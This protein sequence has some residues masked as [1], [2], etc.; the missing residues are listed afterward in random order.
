MAEVSGQAGDKVRIRLAKK[1]VDGILLESHDAGVVLLKLDSGYNIGIPKGNVLDSKIVK[2]FAEKPRKREIK[3]NRD[4]PSIGLVVTGGTIASKLDSR[5]G[6]VKPL[7]DVEEFAKFYPRLFEKVNVKKIETPFMM[8]SE[9]MS[10]RE[11]IKI[12]ESVKKMLDDP[13]IEG[14]IVTHGTDTLHYTAAAL[15]FFLRDLSKPVVLTYSQRSIDRASSDAE[16]NLECA[17]RMVLAEAAEVMLVGHASINDDFCYA[18]RGV[19]VCKLHTSRRDAFKS[20]NERPIA[21]VWPDKVEFLSEYRL[22]NDK[23]KT[24]LDTSFS[25]KVG[26]VKYYP[27]QNSDILDYY[28]KRYK[29]IVIEATGLGHVSGVEA[30]DNWIP[31]LKKM[32]K[33][34]TRV[35]TAPQT[36]Y[37][38][39]NPKVYSNGRELENAGVIFLDEMLSTTAL[40]KLS[41]VLGHRGWRENEKVKEKMLENFSGEINKILTEYG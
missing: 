11:W 29:G 13:G 40:V 3:E 23:G 36:L 32:I 41:W 6:G 9:S 31:K 17:V 24:K 30:R 8:A 1:E 4:L 12:A 5:T 7:T 27:G 15:S 38:G 34:G 35:C 25:E 26:L 37:G 20:I 19:N 10:S 33:E 21:K 2:K 16:L 39:L 22:R 14:V 18:F 28:K